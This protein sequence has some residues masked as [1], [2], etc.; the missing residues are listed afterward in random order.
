[1]PLKSVFSQ[2]VSSIKTCYDNIITCMI[3]FKQLFPLANK[4]MECLI[5]ILNK[6]DRNIGKE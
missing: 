5:V 3:P 2:K 1:M 4:N 6:I